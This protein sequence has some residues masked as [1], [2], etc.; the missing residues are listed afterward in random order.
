MT[1][2]A[3]RIAIAEGV[4]IAR[5]TA[6]HV[7][8]VT[9]NRVRVWAWRCDCGRICYVGA[10][11]VLRGHTKSCG[12]FRRETTANS[13]SVHGNAKR[14]QHTSE[15][16]TWRGIINRTNNPRVP[17]FSDYGGRGITVCE[18]WH[19][20]FSDFL[21]DMGPKPGPEFSIERLD[22]NGNYEPGNCKWATPKEQSQN[23]REA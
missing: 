6:M 2:E 21:T 8:N 7:I 3:Q 15:Y 22:N 17:E 11:D 10:S 4:K 14:R 23:R 5:L 19:N 9:P 20:S 13:K 18:R 1:P 12:C 16:R